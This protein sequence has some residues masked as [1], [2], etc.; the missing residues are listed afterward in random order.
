MSR[1]HGLV[2]LAQFFGE[3]L[4]ELVRRALN[5]VEGFRHRLTLRANPTELDGQ[6]RARAGH[7]PE[8]G[9]RTLNE[10]AA[11]DDDIRWIRSGRHLRFVSWRRSSFSLRLRF[12][13]RRRFGQR[14]LDDGLL[15]TAQPPLDAIEHTLRLVIPVASQHGHHLPAERAQD[16]GPRDMPL[17]H[18]PIAV[19]VLGVDQHT[20]PVLAPIASTHREIAA[21]SRL[22][23]MLVND[24]TSRPK[25]TSQLLENRVRRFMPLDSLTRQR[26]QALEHRSRR[27]RI[28]HGG[29]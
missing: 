25:S 15:L 22:P 16:A 27:A 29:E 5:G 23:D 8:L 2:A 6:H 3:E 11:L 17:L 4:L 9:R 1:L 28:A 13:D 18:A 24:V 26:I 14:L 19:V 21:K 20:E 10:L 12:R 7:L